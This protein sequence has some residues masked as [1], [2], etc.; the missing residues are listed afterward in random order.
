MINTM[1]GF[2]IFNTPCGMISGGL[3]PIYMSMLRNTFCNGPDRR[4]IFGRGHSRHFFKLSGKIMDG[5]I[6]QRFGYLGKIHLFIPDHLLRG[7]NFQKRIVFNDSFAA[8]FM[9]KLLKAGTANEIVGAD[10][11]NRQMCR[12]VRRKISADPCK[13]FF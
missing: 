7:F 10:L 12:K 9:E 8:F 13:G 4:G 5:R 11:L 3:F 6:A 2:V 1:F